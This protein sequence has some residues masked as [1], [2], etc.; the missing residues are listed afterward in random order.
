MNACNLIRLFHAQKQV[1]GIDCS[2]NAYEG[3]L[4]RKTCIVIPYDTLYGAITRIR[5][6]YREIIPYAFTI[7]GRD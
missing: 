6:K 5:D 3:S 7:Y 1:I 4:D 2:T